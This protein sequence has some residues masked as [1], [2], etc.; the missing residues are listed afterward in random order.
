MP[1]S[2]RSLVPWIVGLGMLAALGLAL[3]KGQLEPADF[4]FV[5]GTEVKSLDPAIVTGQPE[6]RMIN[7]LF[8][9]LVGWHPETLEPTPGVAERW[10][11]S[12]DKRTYTFYLRDTAKWSDGT[13]VTA[14]DFYYSMRRFLDPRT[15]A[16]YAYQ[17]WYIKNAKRYSSG[18]RGVRPGD[19]VEVELNLPANAINTRR[20][21]VLRGELVRIEG[22]DG[23]PLSEEELEAAQANVEAS[24]DDWTYVVSLDG[25]ERRFRYA[26]DVDAADEQPPVGVRWCRQVLLDFGEV[27]VELIDDRTVRF[28]I[29]NP[30]PYFI[31]LLGFYPLFPVQ[32]ACVEKYGSPEWTDPERI[33]CNGPFKPLFRRLRDR[34]RVVKNELYWNRDAI[35]LDSVDFLANESIN[36]GLNLYLT[37]KAD[38]I[39]DIPPPALRVLLKEEPPRDDLNP[40]PVL[41]T[42][43]YLLNTTRK[44]LDDVRVRRALSLAMDRE[45]LTTYILA[46]G[47]QPAYSLVPP[48]MPNYEAP[49]C[50][51]EDVEQARKLLAEAGYPGGRG[52]PELEISY[53]THETHQSIAQLIRKQW[54][55]N[56]GIRVR[57]RNEEFATLLSNQ[58]ALN[59]DVSRLSWIGDYADPNT[60][61][62]MFVTGGDNN[63]TG[64]SNAE[65]DRLIRDAAREPDVE[66]RL[67]MLHRAEEIL[68][69]E[70]PLI[71]MYFYVSK[72]MVK[73]YVRGF[74]NNIQDFHPLSSIW[75]DREQETPNPFLKG[76]R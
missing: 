74:Y 67:E 55:Q 11:L 8:E 31:N 61:L 42:Y 27:G 40:Q 37:G 50:E 68:L 66:K 48:G 3:N 26:S 57:T 35:K 25:D 2:F 4:T 62:D 52:F 75:I 56:L 59:Y 51:P 71:P 16:E 7:A 15:A 19:R 72:N 49:K 24:T 28:T 47:E 20:G 44:P 23:E 38:W 45:E 14:G 9:G 1:R 73:P 22:R 60:Y 5:N 41:I 65:Y 34:T 13:R 70:M 21:K 30:T 33:V 18:G 29:E 43:M 32:Q 12:D 36:T 63:R 54:Q 17:A 64:F 53:N 46:S 10:E 69:G 76:R 58:R 6:N 39:Y